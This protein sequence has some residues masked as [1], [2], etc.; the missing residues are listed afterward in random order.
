MATSK[1]SIRTA[2]RHRVLKEIRNRGVTPRGELARLTGLSGGAITAITSELIREGVL[3]EERN[4]IVTGPG[5]PS[6]GIS[7]NP[8]YGLVVGASLRMN[9]LRAVVS[10]YSGTRF[11]H[12]EFTVNTK[13]LDAAALVDFLEQGLTGSLEHI[14]GDLVGMGLALQ[15]DV[16]PEAGRLIWSPVLSCRDV[17]VTTPLSQRFGASVIIANDSVAFASCLLAKDEDFRSGTVGFLMTGH[18]VA[19]SVFHN[20]S[21]LIG[22]SGFV[23]EIGHI[24]RKTGGSPC[25]CGQRGC[26]EAYLAD[27]AI[28]RDAGFYDR[29]ELLNWPDPPHEAMNALAYQART[30]NQRVAA[31]FREAGDALGAA[32]AASISMFKLDRLVLTGRTMEAYDLMKENFEIRIGKSLMP[33]MRRKTPILVRPQR[34]QLIEEGMVLKTLSSLDQSIANSEAKTAGAFAVRK[35]AVKGGNDPGDASDPEADGASAGLEQ[36]L[37]ANPDDRR[38]VEERRRNLKAVR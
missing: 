19:M 17:D 35:D 9:K 12:R 27:Y 33:W 16:D 32:A 3:Q 10:D 34:E 5:R 8:R 29:T 22:E 37:T 24:K 28:Y 31:I 21:P 13:A 18:G 25:R 36:P 7:F 30:G 26:F 1:P 11:S 20:G 6:V 2:N 38:L 23:S 4:R 15:G 14:D